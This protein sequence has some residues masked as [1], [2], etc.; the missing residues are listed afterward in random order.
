M[1]QQASDAAF[2][3]MV[4]SLL[5][6]QKEGDGRERRQRERHQYNCI[7]LLADFDGNSMPAQADFRKVNCQDISA[8]GFSYFSPRKPDTDHVIVALGAI[9]FMFYVAQVMH[10]NP[11]NNDGM[12]EYLVGCRLKNRFTRDG[13]EA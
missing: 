5:E 10:A 9:P 8:T 11:V 7:Q 4:H 6:E 12:V 1:S 3:D 2:F 13:L